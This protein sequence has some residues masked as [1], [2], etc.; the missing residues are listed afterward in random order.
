[1]VTTMNQHQHSDIQRRLNNLAAYGTIAAVDHGRGMVRVDVAG[2]LTDWLPVPGLVGNNFRGSA[3]M[4]VGTQ[5]LVTSPS[6]NLAN[7]VLSGVLYSGGLPPPDTSGNVDVILWND[8]ARVEYDS[9]AKSFLLDVPVPGKVQT[10]VGAA[11]CEITN[12]T[13]RIQ[14]GGSSLTITA[15]GIFLVGPTVGMTVGEGSG[16]ASLVGNFT[17][18]GQLG[19][20]GDVT[21]TGQ[22]M[23]AGGNSNH[24]SH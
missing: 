15:E 16:S 20:T 12:E 10:R 18:K 19:V 6:G 3:P 5:V 7:G 2:R 8:G 4:R 17:M 1:M 23:D 11:T 22:I 13:I 24:H 14:V 21:S 9:A